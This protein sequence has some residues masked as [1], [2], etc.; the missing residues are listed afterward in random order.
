MATT[1]HLPVQASATPPN[2]NTS[3]YKSRKH[4]NESEIWMVELCTSAIFG[5][6]MLIYAQIYAGKTGS[7]LCC[8][9]PVSISDVA[10]LNCVKPN[11]FRR[12]RQDVGGSGF[13]NKSVT[14]VAL[15]NWG[16]DP[17]IHPSSVP[18]DSHSEL[19][20]DDASSSMQSETQ[21]TRGPFNSPML[22]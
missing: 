9:G 2:I 13:Q 12:I 19:R 1:T 20:H 8:V 6:F 11:T 18:T 21:A 17:P 14:S 10:H 5:E 15:E 16:V 4:S 3:P 7:G 22:T